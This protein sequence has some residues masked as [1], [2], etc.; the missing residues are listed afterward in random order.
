MTTTR[1]FS[2][3]FR[4]EG[5]PVPKG[6]PRFTVHGGVYTPK[7]TREAEDEVLWSFKIAHPGHEP[8]AGPIGIDLEFAPTKG[9]RGDIDNYIKTV[10]DALN[11]WAWKDDR[12]I[13]TITASFTRGEARPYTRVHV[14][15]HAAAEEPRREGDR[16]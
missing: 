11:G 14:W 9:R 10:L 4:I 13:E 12:Q 15:G 16:E 1:A 7:M 3:V 6:R 5:E 2:L 8:A